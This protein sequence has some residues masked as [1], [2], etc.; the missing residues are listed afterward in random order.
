MYP[1]NNHGFHR[2]PAPRFSLRSHMLC[3]VSIS[4]CN[5]AS[6]TGKPIVDE[7]RRVSESQEYSGHNLR[8]TML[9]YEVS[10]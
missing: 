10:A 9:P 4:G 5:L 7:H 3:G 2:Y 8:G 6:P 1:S